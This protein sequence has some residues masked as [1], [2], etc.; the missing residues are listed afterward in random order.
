MPR[1]IKRTPE[2]VAKAR[3]LRQE[4]WGVGII[5]RQF[6]V[7]PRTIFSWLND[8]LADTD[9]LRMRERRAREKIP[10]KYR[11]DRVPDPQEVAEQRRL[12]PDDT[13]DLTQQFFGDPIPGDPRRK[14]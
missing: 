7:T 5:A 6:G 9:R 13:R 3:K 2:N 10:Y 4:G 12:I 14:R 11:A 8:V 1:K